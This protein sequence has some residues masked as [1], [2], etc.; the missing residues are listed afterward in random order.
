MS[1]RTPWAL[2]GLCAALGVALALGEQRR[3]AGPARALLPL[4][5][6]AVERVRVSWGERIAD[7]R[8]QEGVWLLGG[9]RADAATVEAALGELELLG[10]SGLAVGARPGASHG[11][12]PP[13]LDVHLQAGEGRVAIAFGD[14]ADRGRAFAA[15]QGE[16]HLVPARARDLWGRGPE[17]LRDPRLLRFDPGSVREIR[18][19]EIRLLRRGARW[20][21]GRPAGARAAP[22]GVRELLE[23][24]GDLRRTPGAAA[25]IEVVD[26]AGRHAADGAIRLEDARRLEEIGSRLLARRPAQIAVAEL[27]ALEIAQGPRRVRL[28]RRGDGWI[29][30]GSEPADAGAVRDLLGAIQ[31][32]H[33]IE[34][35]GPEAAPRAQPVQTSIAW[36]AGGE[37]TELRMGPPRG[38]LRFARFAGEVA[39]Y[40]F[41]DGAWAHPPAEEDAWRRTWDLPPA[42]IEAIRLGGAEIRRNDRFQWVRAHPQGASCDPVRAERLARALA[43][44]RARPAPLPATS[45]PSRLRVETVDGLRRTWHELEVGPPS[46]RGWRHARVGTRAVLVEEALWREANA[47][48]GSD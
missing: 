12:A 35:H 10:R 1:P 30:A 33:A 5:A 29:L 45:Y 19:G 43:A 25:A 34:V 27:D 16:V 46:G 36:E 23:V 11:L 31:R 14:D 47:V 48:V 7:L 9:A 28:R 2:A 8:R 20:L 26:E 22:E 38:K 17:H 44:P 15:V 39:T 40:A 3:A 32:L 21:L 41:A 24:L 6:G 42:S 37:R 13:R 18:V 4:R